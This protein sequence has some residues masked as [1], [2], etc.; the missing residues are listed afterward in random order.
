MKQRFAVRPVRLSDMGRI[1]QIE[2]ASF[3]PDAYDRK[4]FAEYTRKCGDLFLVAVAGTT[5]AGYAIT[6]LFPT[7]APPAKAPPAKAELV[8]LAVHPSF[9]GKGAAQALMD[10][11]LRRL[12]RRRVPRLALTVKL[13]NER[14][15]SFYEKYG[16]RQLRLA[17]RYYEDGT[18]GVIMVRDL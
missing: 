3:G 7:K 14:A 9:L 5:V 13:T 17:P 2:I 15:R 6:C 12:K 11:I 16:F 1:L 18:D 8:S 4:L 10:S